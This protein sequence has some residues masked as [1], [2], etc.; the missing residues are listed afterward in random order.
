MTRLTSPLPAFALGTLPADAQFNFHNLKKAV[1]TAT[2]VP[3]AV[4]DF[5][6]TEA[7]EIELGL[8]ISDRIRD[9]CGVARDPGVT[10]YMSLVWGTLRL[11]DRKLTVEPQALIE[12]W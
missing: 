10:R 1:E 12:P 11:N 3:A 7:E 2:E 8:A 9:R 5:T 4:D 6:F